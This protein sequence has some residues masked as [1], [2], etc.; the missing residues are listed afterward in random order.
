MRQVPL[1]LEAGNRKLNCAHFAA[2]SVCLIAIL[3]A[4]AQFKIGGVINASG[5]PQGT[6]FLTFDDGLDEA[7]P[8]GVS[9]MQKVARFLHGPVSFPSSAHEMPDGSMSAVEK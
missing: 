6:I 8:D 5:T 4:Q 7:G 1:G 3:P 2:L 9:Q